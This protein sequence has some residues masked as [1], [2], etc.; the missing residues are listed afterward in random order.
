MDRQTK[1][2]FQNLIRLRIRSTSII[3]KSNGPMYFCS[4]WGKLY[5]LLPISERLLRVS[6]HSD[7]ISRKNRPNTG[8]KHPAL[9]DDI[10]V[11]T[12]GSKRNHLDEIIDVL[13]KLENAGYRLSENKSEHFKTEIESIGHKTRSKRYQ[14]VTGQTARI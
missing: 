2:D 13:S 12:K 1:S 7:D 5:R 4:H 10:I 3:K 9:L 6:R 11:V 8:E 14:T